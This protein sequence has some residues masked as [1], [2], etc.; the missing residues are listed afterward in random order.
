MVVA[1]GIALVAVGCGMLLTIAGARGPL[2]AWGF[3]PYR[4][5]V[6]VRVRF[7]F[8]RARRGNAAFAMAGVAAGLI[9][10]GGV[11]LVAAAL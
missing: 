1:V 4:R 9:A 8:D 11:T 2:A 7:G 3:E 6:P 10:A 5:A